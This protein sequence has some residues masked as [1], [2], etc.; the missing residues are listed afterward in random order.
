MKS[1]E[2]QNLSDQI[3]CSN[4][5]DFAV[6]LIQIDDSKPIEAA[7]SE[8]IYKA[9]SEASGSITWKESPITRFTRQ[10]IATGEIITL[11]PNPDE[12]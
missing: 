11:E 1:L 8:C 9:T 4:C 3:I 2:P 5:G 6:T 12:P 7:C 10:D